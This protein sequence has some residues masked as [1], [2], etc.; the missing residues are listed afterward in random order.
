MSRIWQPNGSNYDYWRS[1]NPLIA[2]WWRFGDASPKNNYQTPE[3]KGI[4]NYLSGLMVDSG[5]QKHHLKPYFFGT[6]PANT[7]VL[8][9]VSGIAPW[10]LNGSGLKFHCLNAA[11]NKM[12]YVDPSIM[13]EQNSTTAK[14]HGTLSI[15]APMYSGFTIIA[16]IQIPDKV[17]DQTTEQAIIGRSD[18]DNGALATT[19]Q[20]RLSWAQ[21]AGDY[22]LQFTHL[23]N[24]NFT[25]PN[26]PAT[27][28]VSCQVSSNITKFPASS[29][30]ATVVSPN[31]PKNRAQ[32][33][34][35]ACQYR[36]EDSETNRS[37]GISG[38]G[39]ITV[40]IGTQAS[41]LIQTRSFA[42]RGPDLPVIFLSPDLN[43]VPVSLLSESHPRTNTTARDR[44]T[45]SGTIID[46]L[47]VVNDGFL[48][49][50][51]ITHYALSGIRLIETSNPES[52]GFVPEY[53]GNNGLVAYWPFENNGNNTAPATASDPRLNL[54]LSGIAAS[55]FVNGI[56]GG[57]AI[58]I[59]PTTTIANTTDGGTL[60]NNKQ[61]P[62]IPAQSGL[63]L[64]FPSGHILDE[65]MTVIGWMRSVPTGSA[66]NGGGFG[67]LGAAGRHN[68]FFIDSVQAGVA[69]N[70]NTLSTGAFASGVGNQRMTSF[71][72]T[73]TANNRPGNAL[74]LTNGANVVPEFDRGDDGWHLW[75]G[76]YDLKAG[77]MY[78]V[79]DAKHLIPMTQQISSSSGWSSEG[80]G[81]N[82]GF[83]GFFP[84]STGSVEFDN[85]A[86]YRRVLSIPE[87]SGFALRNIQQPVD[88]HLNTTLKSLVGFWP[89]DQITSYAGG[90][91][92]DDKSW[93]FHHLTNLSG[94][95]T[96]GTILNTDIVDYNN[97]LQTTG[98]GAMISLERIFHGSN[99]DAS[100]PT[101]Y[102]LSGMSAGTWIFLP[103]GDLSTQGQGSSGL[104]GDHMIMG[105]WDQD[106]FGRSWFLGVRDNKFHIKLFDNEFALNEFTSTRTVPFNTPFFIGCNIFP[107]GGFTRAQV[108][109]AAQDETLEATYAIDEQFGNDHTTPNPVGASGLSL[110]NVPNMQLGF[111]QT[112]RIGLAFMHL[113]YQ[114][115]DQWLLTK[116]AAILNIPLV[117]GGVSS[118]DPA[119][120]S[121]WRMN[122]PINPT[123]DFGRE[124]NHLTLV[125]PDAHGIG[126]FKAIH[127]SGVVIRVPEYLDS[128][129]NNP[130]SQRLD[131]GSGT[132]S[133]TLL[134][135]VT[136]P[137]GASNTDRHVI[138]NKGG[139]NDLEGSGIQV[140]TPPDSLQLIGYASGIT[141]QANN[142]DLAPGSWNHIA[143]IYDRDNNKFTS[144]VNC[145][146]AGT[147]Q[148]LLFG[149]PVNTSGFALGGR[150]DTQLD[151]IAGGSAFSGI[152]DDFMIFGRALTLPEISGLAANSYS[153]AKTAGTQVTSLIGG[154]LSGIPEQIV[155]G[156]IASYIH[157]MAQDLSWLGGYI[158]GTSGIV[159]HMGGY[160]YGV[161]NL[162]GIGI[163]SFIHGI[164]QISG[165]YA[166]F[167]H[168]MGIA[169][170]VIGAYTIGA[171][172]A[173]SEFDITFNFQIVAAKDFDSRLEVVKSQY[174]NFDAM[175][176]VIRITAPPEC[177]MQLPAV[178]HIASGTPYTLTVQGSGWAFENKSIAKV[179]FTFADFK[180]A[181][182]GTLIGGLPFSGLFQASRTFNTPG[183]Y[184]IK[185]EVTDSYGYRHSCVRPFLL[186]PSGSTSGAYLSTLPRITLSGNPVDGS[187]IQRIF[188]TYSLSGISTTSGLLEYTDFADQQETLLNGLEMPTDSQFINF[189]RTHDYT[190]PG[191]YTPVWAVSGSWGVVSDS[192][193]AGSDY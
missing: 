19:V 175:M 156:L 188:L 78:I 159:D 35:I 146:Y 167:L 110:L 71:A 16:W 107:S 60:L 57:K 28:V 164:G 151:P 173:L 12:L 11:D 119:N 98:S 79:R 141:T 8:Q 10:A 85:F 5:P 192:I 20:W 133:W 136:P 3:E 86:V 128:L 191:S 61:Y 90:N 95:F 56:D 120:I 104:Y 46:E 96:Q 142:G 149:I 21:N 83:F 68:A 114:T 131:L 140:Y 122:E 105:A 162:S 69:V 52:S 54:S 152:L 181:E 123:R 163:G 174:Q 34:W 39:Q 77:Q 14:P 177:T 76:V 124:N 106:T 70:T 53:P 118:T 1:D 109:Y 182:S 7:Q 169:S 13:L 130:Q 145:R 99:L 135:W 179:R 185:M 125:N 93:Y 193:S 31:F 50:D 41:G 190:M 67:W 113:G 88:A 166:G 168:G 102:S 72:T 132:Q 44:H 100:L 189:V 84:V 137:D 138:M 103:S 40:Y 92:V 148:Q 117:S 158:I 48:S 184:T 171:G 116:R 43:G 108:V 180:G 24:T 17:P 66:L 143:L 62:A 186:V 178:G 6:N 74:G 15:G 38:S 2:A 73:A 87:M 157:G 23:A 27:R 82:Q 4:S 183:W 154:Y 139:G 111:P 101:L 129:P 91:R 75:A 59:T 58:R 63:A 126:N 26:T 176:G 172:E 134:G 150:G 121:H 144:V 80:L 97:A 161:G 32:P 51:R 112:T 37:Y 187:A 36:R 18:Q 22:A 29:N 170:G 64:L 81:V 127:S 55:A 33:F 165:L 49:N 65:G 30:V 42:F 89:L 147:T 94:A 155:S 160:I 25:V 115:Y 47:I 153:F 45:A 9:P